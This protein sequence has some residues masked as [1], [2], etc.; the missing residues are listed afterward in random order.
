MLLQKPVLLDHFQTLA[1]QA[2]E[3]ET[4]TMSSILR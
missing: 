3:T 2:K 4:D 1:E